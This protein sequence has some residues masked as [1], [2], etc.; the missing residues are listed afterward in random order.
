MSYLRKAWY[1]KAVRHFPPRN[2]H[3]HDGTKI[4]KQAERQPLKNRDVALIWN[5]DLE[6]HAENPREER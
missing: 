3:D 6:Y 1:E 4:G 2:I 5:K